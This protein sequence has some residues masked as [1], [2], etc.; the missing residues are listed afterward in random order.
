MS[1]TSFH[2][3]TWRPAWGLRTALIALISFM[4]TNG[5]G[6]IGALDYDEET[7]AVYAKRSKYWVCG[8]CGCQNATCLPEEVDAPV[9][10]LERD[11]EIGISV[12]ESTKNNTGCINN[13]E[14]SNTD[15]GSVT[16][17][18]KETEFASPASVCST[19]ESATT[20]SISLP[21]LSNTAIK[22]PLPSIT[23]TT[24]NGP[25]SFT[26]QRRLPAATRT[27]P[28]V[29]PIQADSNTRRLYF[30]FGLI[31]LIVVRRIYMFL[32]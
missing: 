25:D 4:T 30:V 31:I 26:R 27:I 24:Q 12:K 21:K 23:T 3:E 32:M 2:Q 9:Q 13:L 8:I 17:S 22:S 18:L 10:K 14:N 6:A 20:A 15:R 7:R 1:I 11:P 16:D 5:E 29:Q 28:A 19:S